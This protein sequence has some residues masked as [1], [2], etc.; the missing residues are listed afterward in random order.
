VVDA[1]NVLAD[2]FPVRAAIAAQLDVSVV[3]AR[4]D[5]CRE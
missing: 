5:E 3:G 4:P 2:F 1:W